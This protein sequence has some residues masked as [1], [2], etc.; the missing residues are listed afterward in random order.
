VLFGCPDYSGLDVWT[1]A[2]DPKMPVELKPDGIPDGVI[3]AIT[4]MGD[5]E[6][7]SVF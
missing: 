3:M 6:K 4:R 5:E 2:G 7:I 1:P